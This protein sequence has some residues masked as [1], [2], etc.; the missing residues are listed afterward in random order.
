MSVLTLERL[1]SLPER[2]ARTTCRTPSEKSFEAWSLPLV[3][4]MHFRRGK[5]ARALLGAGHMS[6]VGEVGTGVN[7]T[8]LGASHILL[9]RELCRE[10]LRFDYFVHFVVN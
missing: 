6:R 3:Y 1:Y 5:D 9:H 2:D 8:S 4:C 7:G 10:L